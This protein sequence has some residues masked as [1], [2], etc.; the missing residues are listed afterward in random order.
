[1]AIIV[2]RSEAQLAEA[3]A[4]ASAEVQTEQ[5]GSND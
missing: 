1:M 2:L 4:K 3:H 5:G